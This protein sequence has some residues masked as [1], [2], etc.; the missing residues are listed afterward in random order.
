M[1][2]RT[3]A[4]T[5]EITVRDTGVGMPSEVQAQIF[6]PFFTTKSLD[7]GTGL[8]LALVREII[9]EHGGTIAVESVPGEGTCF[10]IALPVV[11]EGSE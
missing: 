10:T 4:R 6:E 11:S 5:V 8:G 2:T 7:Q 1:T 9:D 3:D